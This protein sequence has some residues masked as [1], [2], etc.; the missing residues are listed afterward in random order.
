MRTRTL[1]WT[2]AA[3]LGAAA[4]AAAQAPN[5]T[6]VF[7][8]GGQT[9]TKAA[10]TVAGGNLQGATALLVSGTGVKAQIT[11]N[12]EGGALP[13]ELEIAPD[14]VPGMREVR[15]VTP[16]G[17]SN[18]GRMWI[19][20]Y[21]E[22]AEK[23]PNNALAAA[24]KLEKLPVALHGQ[25]SGGEDVDCYTFQAGAGDTFV[26]DL[27]AARMTSA[28]DGYL[29]LFDARGKTL[30][31]AVEGFDRDPRI[32]HTFKTAGTYAIQVRD[33]M[34]RGGAPYVY[35]LT[36]GKVPV[37]TGYLPIGG[38]RGYPVEV[39]LE[40]VNLGDMKTMT[41]TMPAEG[42]LLTVMPKTAAGPAVSP[43][44]LLPTDQMED[45]EYEPND[46]PEQAMT[47]D[48]MPSLVSGRMDKPGD[49]D[50]YRLKA[51]AAGNL[52]FEIHARR[53][54]SRLD[55][56]M[57]ILDAAGKE[58]STN[59]DGAGKDSRIT[60]GVEAGKEYLVEVRA[61]DRRSG[62]DVF[63]RLSVNPPGTPDFA[64]TV[65]PDEINVGQS[66]STLLTVNITRTNG[67]N[68]PVA[69]RV[70]GLP[71]GLTASYAAIPPGA[72]NA[73]FTLTAAPGATPGA[74][75]QIRVVGAARIGEADVERVAQPLETYQPPLAQANQTATRPTQI[76]AATVM[77]PTAYALDF[78]QREI[79]VKKG[80]MNLD[81]K[82]KAIRQMGQNGAIALT[83][84]GLP[85]NVTL[86]A[87]PIAQNANEVVL[88][89]N[90]AANAPATTANIIITGNLNN[91][92]QVAPALKLTVT[93]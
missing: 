7:P 61:L 27:V 87:A 9:G 69:L 48:L 89:L 83:V 18:A 92:Q 50:L 39:A 53:L 30:Q 47:L 91:N 32:I 66:G 38:K 14:A 44:S 40:G 51:A 76:F 10:V 17:S 78:E 12:T 28:L 41:V 5:V 84:A 86:A 43:I 79:T 49:V 60:L 68:A 72:Q 64:L 3:A 29:T 4:P 24:Q 58:L 34:F 33:T 26:F 6:H 52:T 85:G 45:T 80:T 11:K 55:S 35:K 65:T 1:L 8:P 73:Q 46:A 37:V 75:G 57:R 59:D 15:V 90:V 77:P 67:F 31:A 82:V 22:L 56:F 23:E 81:V 19:G 2:V 88:K 36:L 93:D 63:Y 42:N 13:V 74:M 21:P 16:R 25:A 54:G 71:E 70:D 20:A 62:G